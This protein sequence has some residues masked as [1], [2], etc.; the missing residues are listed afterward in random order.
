MCQDSHALMFFQ[1][2]LA[3]LA[4]CG[5][6]GGGSLLQNSTLAFSLAVVQYNLYLTL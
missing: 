5:H 6:G 1:L 2:G 3:Q 4:G